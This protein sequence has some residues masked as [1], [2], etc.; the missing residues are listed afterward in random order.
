M[1][2][3]I[4]SL[5][6]IFIFGIEGYSQYSAILDSYISEGL[7]NNLTLKQ[8]NLTFQQYMEEITI[9]RGAFFPSVSVNARYTVADGGRLIEFPV[10]DL[11][12]PVY[13]TLHQLTRTLPPSQQF[14]QQQVENQEFRFYRPTEHE[15]KL[16]LVQPIFYPQIYHNHKMKQQLA[17]L[18]KI[19]E[20]AFKRQLIAEIKVSYFNYL[21]T[22]E[23]EQVLLNSENVVRENIRV[24][25][26]LFENDKVT[27]D[28]VY[29]AEAEL[30]KLQQQKASVEKNKSA[31]QGYFNFLLNKPL[32]AAITSDSGF[33][34]TGIPEN[35]DTAQHVAVL[36]SKDLEALHVSLE[37]AERN[38]SLQKASFLPTVSAVIDY[39]FQGETYEFTG[40]DDFVLASLVLQWEIF[41]GKQN[42]AALEKAKIN[43]EIQQARIEEARAA[44][45][46]DVMNLFHEIEARKKQIDAA[47]KENQANKAVFE[48]I[49]KKYT[50]GRASMLEFTDA[51]TAY[52]NSGQQLAIARYDYYILLAELEKTLGLL[53]SQNHGNK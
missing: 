49:R 50:E 20:E 18:G 6:F 7:E 30:Q 28:N 1:K 51:R 47:E 34:F 43:Q 15:T 10:G 26:S 53:T 9:A 33:M 40:S 16:A 27:I 42:K 38:I 48:I 12:N 23:L 31:A 17:L 19:D 29:K 2:I 22:L 5:L 8:K 24:N 21:K 4:A 52:Q 32:D 3:K 46:L 11:L 25:K 45:K 41:K 13:S 35:L 14:P 36:N 44:I 37:I 39:G